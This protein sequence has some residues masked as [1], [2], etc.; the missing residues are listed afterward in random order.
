MAF[1]SMKKIFSSVFLSVLPFL[2]T[3]FLLPVYAA[4]PAQPPKICELQGTITNVFN[5][6]IAAVP[7]VALA[8]LL[9]GAVLWYSSAG[10]PQKLQLAQS[11][12]MYGVI[13]MVVGMSAVL[14]VI[15][16][17][18]FL[19]GADF[20]W[21][22]VGVP[23]LINVDFCDIEAGAGGGLAGIGENGDCDNTS[24]CDLGLVCEP[25]TGVNAGSNICVPESGK[26][27]ENGI[28]TTNPSNCARGL[29]CQTSGIAGDSDRYCKRP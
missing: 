28:C 23:G 6:V 8:V 27:A 12:L 16:M 22:E 19:L 14:I 21:T 11:T 10:D 17:E 20:H 4:D 5:F 3:T 18:S 15:T 24:E 7:F 9:Y 26:I 1:I 25:G 29:T 2:S 13:G